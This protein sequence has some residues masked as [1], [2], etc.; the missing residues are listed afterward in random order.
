VWPD[1]VTEPGYP[2][3]SDRVDDFVS[4]AAAL[5]DGSVWLSSFQRGLARLDSGGGVTAR[6]T[7]SDG[8]SSNKV[9]SI[10]ADPLDGSIWAGTSYAGISRLKGGAFTTYGGALFGADL[11]N[12]RIVDIQSFGSGNGR[13]MVVSFGGSDTKA[14]AVGIYTG[15]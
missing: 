1:A 15:P 14:G 13:K 9:F 12:Q 2:K 11:M 4:G 3:P 5:P 8:L 10:A 6:V 7:T